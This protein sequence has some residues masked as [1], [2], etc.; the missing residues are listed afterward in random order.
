MTIKNSSTLN[1]DEIQKMLEDAEK[2][3]EID[4]K[5]RQFAELKTSAEIL[6]QE[7]RQKLEKNEI[8]NTNEKIEEIKILIK[9][10]ENKLN[11]ENFNE[12]KD[13]FDKLNKSLTE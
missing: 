5:K 2:Y 3:A 7:L 12:L 8:D 11:T 13:A 10:V 6:C 1:D 9:D 4:Q